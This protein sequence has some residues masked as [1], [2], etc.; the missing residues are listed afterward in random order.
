[1]SKKILV[2][3]NDDAT[4]RI[5]TH[6]GRALKLDTLVIH[7]WGKSLNLVQDEDILLVFFNVE[8]GI[9]NI[10]S[11]LKYFPQD[12]KGE[13]EAIVPVYF[14]FNKLFSPQF[15]AA[16]KYNHAGDLKK[17]VKLEVL[18]E[19]FSRVIDVD[20]SLDY[21]EKYYR[22]KWEGVKRYLEK[23]QE[24]MHQLESILG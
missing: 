8:L 6:L 11:F 1:M 12:K 19:I 4:I 2:L 16:K 20:E 9:V 7:N 21:T 18:V 15:Q 17:P 5:I 14:L 3:D 13:E 24:F 10:P 23:T 22:N